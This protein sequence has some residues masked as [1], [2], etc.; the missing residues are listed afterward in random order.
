MYMTINY[1]M[2]AEG[3]SWKG[4][5]GTKSRWRKLHEDLTENLVIDISLVT[6]L[7]TAQVLAF[8]WPKS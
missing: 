7:P 1:K 2:V 6:L 3:H 4:D 8:N 5:K